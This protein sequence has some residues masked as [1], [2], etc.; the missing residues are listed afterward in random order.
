MTLPSE[1]APYTEDIE[2]VIETLNR[3]ETLKRAN[4]SIYSTN[5]IVTRIDIIVNRKGHTYWEYTNV[6]GFAFR[7]QHEAIHPSCLTNHYYK[8]QL[9]GA[10]LY[11]FYFKNPSHERCTSI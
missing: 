3:K 2:F 8:T 6:G 11:T 4:I 9:F 5:L 10:P 7:L 1:Y